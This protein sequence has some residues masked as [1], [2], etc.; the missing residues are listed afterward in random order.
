M[1]S[2]ILP[3]VT[4]LALVL[5]ACTGA[6]PQEPA[7]D[8]EQVTTDG[9]EP[10]EDTGES[11]DDGE[12]TASV[13][14]EVEGGDLAGSYDAQGAKS[15]CNTADDGSGATFLD[16]DATDGIYS[17]TFVSGEGGADPE[18][19]HFSVGFAGETS[20]NDDPLGDFEEIVVDTG[21]FGT[22]P[23]GEGTAHMTDSGDTITWEVQG[24][25]ADGVAFTGSITC[26][27]VDRR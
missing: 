25:S 8:E 10:D 24:T 21:V 27:P 22:E 3:A 11:T 9:A 15:D 17:V 2:R 7:A 20:F 13:Q 23:E 5:A 18:A 14:V 12:G 4:V 16:M 1:A 26:G 6:S 19:F